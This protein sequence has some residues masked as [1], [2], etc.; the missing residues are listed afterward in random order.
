[1]RHLW[2]CVASCCTAVALASPAAG[3]FRPQTRLMGF[4]DFSYVM[5]TREGA[6]EGFRE[7]QLVGHIMS[8]LN[9]RVHFFSEVSA[10]AIAG[11]FRVEV[12]RVGLQYE[13]RD[14]LKLRLSR[15]RADRH[16]DR[17]AISRIMRAAGE[18]FRQAGRERAGI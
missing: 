7:G 15:A 10:T 8:E 6:A 12:E 18:G 5:T 9:E 17:E 3:Q 2:L 11:G 14:A 16:S 1:M 4:A 13:I